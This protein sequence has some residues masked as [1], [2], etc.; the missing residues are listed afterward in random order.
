M[1]RYMTSSAVMDVQRP[2]APPPSGVTPPPAPPQQPMPPQVPAAPEVPQTPL[3]PEP[4]KRSRKGLI[5]A[6]IMVVVIA[7]CLIAGAVFMYLRSQNKA[8]EPALQNPTP[9][10][11]LDDG[12]IDP[13][14]I[15][16]TVQK[17][18]GALTNLNDSADFGPNDLNDSTL[19]L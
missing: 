3:Q 19:G 9:A 11:S 5:I 13:G 4:Q 6:I 16:A 10:Q 12:H 14:D 7:L 8:D 2:V 1:N 18:D 17:I 15:D